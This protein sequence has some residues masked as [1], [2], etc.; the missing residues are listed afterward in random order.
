MQRSES[1]SQ[2]DGFFKTIAVAGLGLIGG[3]VVKALR[4]KGYTGRILGIDPDAD[5]RQQALQSGLLDTVSPGL[6]EDPALVDLL[7]LA[8]PLSRIE[9]ALGSLLPLLGPGTLVT[10]AGSVKETVHAAV[11]AVL[12]PG[13]PFVGGHPMAGSDRSG[14]GSASPI[15]FE[16]AYYFIT[17]EPG[18]SP[19]AVEG[20]RRFSEALGAIPVITT[21]REHDALAARLSHLPHLTACAL[22]STFVAALPEE[23]LKYAGG[24]F[25]DTTRIAMGDPGLWRD[26]FTQNRNELIAGIDSLT[27]ELMRFRKQL[28]EEKSDEIRYNLSITQRIRSGLA[29]RRPREESSLYP[30][31]LDVE[32]RPG[33]LAAVT[34]LLAEKQVNIKDIAL[35]HAREALPGALILSFASAAE[36][37]RAADLIRAA[38]L[39]EVFMEQD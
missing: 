5:N 14:F 6:P 1:P 3:S 21:P 4:L 10:D 16:N 25:R 15:L 20:L 9:E 35:D 2:E 33:S 36:R 11:R 8:V 34:G 26:I 22:V 32:D 30:L 37:A 31:A 7:L 18:S 27:A 24:G 39:C 12:P 19:S 17:P 28:T 23:A 29:A 38:G 13:I